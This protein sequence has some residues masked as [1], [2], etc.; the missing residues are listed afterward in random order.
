MILIEVFADFI[1]N[2]KSL[3][4]YVE[5]RK[6]INDRGEFNDQTLLQAEEDLQRLK[7]EEPE[8]LE[9]MYTVLE[10][11]YKEDCGH[12]TEYPIN[13]IREILKIYQKGIPAK[14]VL[15]GYKEGLDHHCHNAN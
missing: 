6:T 3:K 4:E 11:Y 12:L 8:V 2:K 5:L 10:R 13:F 14:K 9:E 15:K 1:R 7:Q